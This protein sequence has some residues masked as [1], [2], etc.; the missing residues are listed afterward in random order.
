MRTK[1]TIK[2]KRKIRTRMALRRRRGGKTIKRWPATARTKKIRRRKKRKI[3]SKIKGRRYKA[4]LGEGTAPPLLP[5]RP[6][7]PSPCPHSLKY[8]H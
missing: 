1:K 7:S 8:I 5:A 4:Q 6:S 2:R 3:R